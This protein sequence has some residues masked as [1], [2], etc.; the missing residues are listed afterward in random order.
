M[1]EVGD[2]RR[3]RKRTLEDKCVGTG[4]AG[5]GIAGSDLH[6]IG[7]GVTNKDANLCARQSILGSAF[8]DS[9]DYIVAGRSIG[10]VTEGGLQIA[11]VSKVLL[12][13]EKIRRPAFAAPIEVIVPRTGVGVRTKSD[14]QISIGC[15]IFECIKRIGG[16]TR[17]IALS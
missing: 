16:Q 11:I 8:V 17:I 2:G 6:R 10:I 13:I 3:R 5:H 14:N 9:V 15:D 1:R 4:A 7:V 12:R